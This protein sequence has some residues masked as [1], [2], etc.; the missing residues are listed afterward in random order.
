MDEEAMTAGVDYC[1]PVKMSHKGFCLAT[2]EHL[3]NYLLG[4]SYI[5]IK[6]TLIVPGGIPILSIGYKY[7]SSNFLGL[8]ATE[9]SGST[10]TGDPYLYCFPEIYSY[11]SALPVVCPQF[12][13]KYFN[14]CNAIDSRSRMWQSDIEL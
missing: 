6:S 2:L 8:I 12:L 7:N 1:R 14:A 13:G 11:V 10:E 4:G 3:I 9:G 5:F